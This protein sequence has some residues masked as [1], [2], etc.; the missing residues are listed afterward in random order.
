MAVPIVCICAL[1]GLYVI[2][3]ASACESRRARMFLTSVDDSAASTPTIPASKGFTFR[4]PMRSV[5]LCPILPSTSS[6]VCRSRVQYNEFG[7]IR[8]TVYTFLA[9]VSVRWLHGIT[10]APGW[11]GPSGRLPG[12]E[13]RVLSVGERNGLGTETECGAF[14]A[15]T[16]VA[17]LFLA[18][19]EVKDSLGLIKDY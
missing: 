12:R 2:F 9:S 5:R 4:S 7:G 6:I 1:L 15:R 14:F 17:Q 11:Q 8:R 3:Y 16:F 19:R 10:S 13:M 18:R